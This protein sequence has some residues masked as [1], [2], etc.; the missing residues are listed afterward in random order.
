LIDDIA[1]VASIE[2]DENDPRN[3][4]PVQELEPDEQIEVVLCAKRDMKDLISSEIKAGR[5]VASGLWYMGLS[6]E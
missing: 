2:I 1:Y 5:T 4:H 6:L 3:K